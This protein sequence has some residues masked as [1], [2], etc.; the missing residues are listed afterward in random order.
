[1][2][3]AVGGRW[4]TVSEHVPAA[5]LV[6]LAAYRPPDLLEARTR[7]S[8]GEHQAAVIGIP[9][10][11]LDG[12]GVVNGDVPADQQEVRQRPVQAHAEVR[13]LG[14]RR[15]LLPAEDVL[16][17]GMTGPRPPVRRVANRIEAAGS[18][19]HGDPECVLAADPVR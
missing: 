1:I 3:S 6:L 14:E 19:D 12:A 18:V 13:D 16:G 9:L 11:Q 8:L 17:I 2:A 5:P 7:N 10:D 15:Y 4:A